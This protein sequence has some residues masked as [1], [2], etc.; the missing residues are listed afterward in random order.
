MVRN[1]PSNVRQIPFERLI[2]QAKNAR[3]EFLREKFWSFWRSVSRRKMST[4]SRIEGPGLPVG[5]L[6]VVWLLFYSLLVVH[7]LTTSYTQRLAKA[8][9]VQDNAAG[10]LGEA[11]AVRTSLSLFADT[12]AR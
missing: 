7:G 1:R 11:Q 8:W 9:T 4:R 5:A 10:N 12:I 2:E 6:L 3:T